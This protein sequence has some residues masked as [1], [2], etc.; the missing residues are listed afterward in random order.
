MMSTAQAASPP[1]TELLQHVAAGDRA[2]IDAV[3]AALYPDLKRIARSRLHQQGHGDGLHTTTLVHE[4]FVRLVHAKALN[5]QGRRHFFAYAAKVMRNIIVDSAREHQAERRG[6]GAEHV[7]LS[8]DEVEQLADGDGSA[9]LVAVHDA[10]RA[11]ETVDPDLA[12][13][14]EMRYFGG[15][16]DEE[17]AQL[18]GVTDRTVR[19]RWDKARAWLYVALVDAGKA[20]LA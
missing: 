12:E 5:L 8:G 15:Y 2:A 11:L 7:T 16:S 4:S 17:I 13:L 19:R 1:I 18:L 20:P 14:V 6:G 10:V 9:E 3:F